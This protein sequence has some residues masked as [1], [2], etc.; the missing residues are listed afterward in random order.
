MYSAG[1]GGAL[2]S[3]VEDKLPPTFARNKRFATIEQ[4]LRRQL[5][6]KFIPH[7]NSIVRP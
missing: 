3:V 5:P 6:S 4:V 7:N 1:C 2:L